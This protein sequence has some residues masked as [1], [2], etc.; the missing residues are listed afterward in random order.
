MKT[1]NSFNYL[2]R[3]KWH[4]IVAK[5]LRGINSKHNRDLYC[6]NCLDLFITKRKLHKKVCENKF[7]CGVVMP[8][9]VTKILE[10]NHYQKSDKAPSIIYADIESLIK[11]I[12][13][14]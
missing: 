11:R 9:E 8:F 13:E 3:R 6:L 1:N 10:I 14:Y 4:Y 7:C 2:K 12:N 5:K